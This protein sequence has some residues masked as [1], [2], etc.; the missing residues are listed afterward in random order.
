MSDSRASSIAARGL[1]ASTLLVGGAM[2]ALV[3]VYG[4]LSHLMFTEQLTGGA[5][6]AAYWYGTSLQVLFAIVII[7]VGLMI[8]WHQHVGK[9]WTL[10]GIGVAC[11]AVGDIIWTVLDLHLGIEPYP[12]AADV[13]YTLEYVFF[14]A[15]LVLAIRSY[16]G[17]TKVRT[18]V[19]VGLLVS[20]VAAAVL[21]FVLL[22]PYIFAAGVAELGLWG[23]VMSTLYPL[24]DVFFMLGPAVALTLIIGQLGA[25]KL[26]WP[27]W[28]VVA[29]ALVFSLADSM[30]SYADWSGAGSSA[31]M[32]MGW[33]T[34]NLLFALAALVARD[35]Y[36]VR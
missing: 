14:L 10:L 25:G 30:Y 15:A 6:A 21:Y 2:T 12:S 7:S 19:Y 29:G 11:Y 23:F 8:G 31:L 35:V 1:S 22:R 5:Y 9:Q 4:V 13:F 32:E 26:A 28:L 36:R 20:G 16:S 17:I 3:A 18:P 24:G 33:M 34:A 27:W